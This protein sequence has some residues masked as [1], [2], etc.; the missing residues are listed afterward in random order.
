MYCISTGSV[1][2][3]G[4]N[5]GLLDCTVAA[6]H[7]VPLGTDVEL[8]EWEADGTRV[9]SSNLGLWLLLFLTCEWVTLAVTLPL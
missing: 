3:A 4:V 6:D 8:P 9:L 5:P 7:Q 2:R 1:A